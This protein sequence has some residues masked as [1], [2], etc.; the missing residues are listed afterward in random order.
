MYNVVY[1]YIEYQ[2]I[3]SAY[4]P[5]AIQRKSLMHMIPLSRKLI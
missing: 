3:P 1:M 5:S 4:M 2:F